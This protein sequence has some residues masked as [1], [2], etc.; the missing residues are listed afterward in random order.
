[1]TFLVA[2]V[3]CKPNGK[4]GVVRETPKSAGIARGT[5]EPSKPSSV[6]LD[7]HRK[8][9]IARETYQD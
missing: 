8:L 4:G 7:P 6:D 5:N 2:R 9:T 3:H 1:M